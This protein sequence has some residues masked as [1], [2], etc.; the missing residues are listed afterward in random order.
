MNFLTAFDIFCVFCFVSMTVLTA[1][2]GWTGFNNNPKQVDKALSLL[3][4]A[5]FSCGFAILSMET[6][7]RL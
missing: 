7:Q 4:G 3:L 2:A 5:I 1:A 6:L